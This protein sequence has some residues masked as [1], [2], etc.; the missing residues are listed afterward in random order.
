VINYLIRESVTKNVQLDIVDEYVKLGDV[1]NF[2][3]YTSDMWRNPTSEV[4]YLVYDPN[5]VEFPELA[6]VRKNE[7]TAVDKATVI[8]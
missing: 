2:E 1:T 4:I 7:T 3:I 5:K 6:T 8:N